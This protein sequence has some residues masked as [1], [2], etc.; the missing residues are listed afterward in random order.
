MLRKQFAILPKSCITKQYEADT[1]LPTK[2][3]TDVRLLLTIS[4]KCALNTAI[5]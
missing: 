1:I 2:S 5:S 3:G 4:P